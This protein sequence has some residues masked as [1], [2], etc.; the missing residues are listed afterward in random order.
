MFKYFF[1]NFN[2]FIYSFNDYIVILC[3]IS[4]GT[5][6]Q[7]LPT[8]YGRNSGATNLFW[9]KVYFKSQILVYEYWTILDHLK[10]VVEEVLKC[11]F[12]ENELSMVLKSL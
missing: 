1:F 12:D 2:Y 3:I 4:N 5:V 6:H 7:R 9:E 8:V 10:T 11:H